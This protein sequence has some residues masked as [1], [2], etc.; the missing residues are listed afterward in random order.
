MS[1]ILELNPIIT[2]Y[3]LDSP[4]G[5][6]VNNPDMIDDDLTCFILRM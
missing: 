3:L 2:P 6:I 4:F 5:S 1:G